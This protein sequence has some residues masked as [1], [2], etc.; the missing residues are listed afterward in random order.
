MKPTA[1]H[2][3]IVAQVLRWF[4]DADLSHPAVRL[5]FEIAVQRHRASIG[6]GPRAR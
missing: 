4:R 5:L 3:P 6:G 1:P 2:D